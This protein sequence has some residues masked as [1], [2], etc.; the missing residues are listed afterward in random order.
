M[1]YSLESESSKD[2]CNENNKQE[3]TIQ[4]NLLIQTF[5]Y[6]SSL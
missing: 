2:R 6:W 1:L 5:G 3:S 4:V